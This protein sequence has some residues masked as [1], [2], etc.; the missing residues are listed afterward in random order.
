MAT[1]EVRHWNGRFPEVTRV[2]YLNDG[3]LRSGDNALSVDWFDIT[4]VN[5]TMREPF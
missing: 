4:V 2:R 1:R 5:A 3:L